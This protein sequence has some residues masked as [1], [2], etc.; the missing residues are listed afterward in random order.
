MLGWSVF[1]SLVLR[2]MGVELSF[3]IAQEVVAES[4]N[5]FETHKKIVLNSASKSHL[6][7]K[8]FNRFNLQRIIPS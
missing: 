2:N 7:L 5:Y 1:P 6:E 4:L 8:G 3:I